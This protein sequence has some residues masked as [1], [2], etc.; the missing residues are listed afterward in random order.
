MVEKQLNTNEV[1]QMLQEGIIDRFTWGIRVK[2]DADKFRRA[3]E[4]SLKRRDMNK[5]F[6]VTVSLTVIVGQYTVRHLIHVEKRHAE[7]D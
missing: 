6:V 1:A 7:K 4:S 5:D 2:E 3:V